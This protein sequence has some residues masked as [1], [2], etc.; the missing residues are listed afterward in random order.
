[1]HG[2]VTAFV[3]DWP[4]EVL[5]R[6][7]FLGGNGS[8]NYYHWMIE[9][10]PKLKYIQDLGDEC[11][12]FPLLVS[13]DAQRIPTFR[14]ALNLIAGEVPVVIMNRSRY[15]RV[16]KLVYVNSPSICPFNLRQGHELKV[17][18]FLTHG[19]SINFLRNRLQACAERTKETGRKRIF[20]ARRSGRRNYNQDEIFELFE[21]QGFIRVFMEELNLR[22]QI[23]LVSASEMIAGPTGAAWTNLI[24]CREGTKCLC[25]MAE[26]SREFSAY[27]NLA[28]IV[29]AD[30]RY[31]TYRTDAKSTEALTISTI[32]RM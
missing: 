23:E 18:D 5:E 6:G 24:F 32:R 14:E 12:G 27:S 21:A 9:L 28:K 7:I 17:S 4:T 15:Y 29:G 22:S 26:Q 19:P 30:L 3:S 16:E 2:Q 25:W 8:F 31:V 10:L 20:F 13:E 1:M 11:A